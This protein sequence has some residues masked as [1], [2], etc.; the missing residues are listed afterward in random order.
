[1]TLKVLTIKYRI[2]K[3]KKLWPITRKVFNIQM[4]F[5]LLADINEMVSGQHCRGL[6]PAKIQICSQTSK[7]GKKDR[8]ST[9]IAHQPCG[10]G[11][12]QTLSQHNSLTSSKFCF[13]PRF[14][15]LFLC[16]P[17]SLC[18]PAHKNVLLSCLVKIISE[19]KKSA[20]GSSNKYLI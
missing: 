19:W 17:S 9:V 13:F 2:S 8:G 15:S 12:Q 16:L 4:R 5:L 14:C 10:D 7:T 20:N 6:T 3:K 18:L 1:M 11:F